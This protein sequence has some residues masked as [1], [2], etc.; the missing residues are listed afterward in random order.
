MRKA[1]D[2]YC[3]LKLVRNLEFLVCNAW[4]RNRS[5]PHSTTLRVATFG[6][7]RVSSPDL[8]YLGI[9]P[10][11]M[12]RHKRGQNKYYHTVPRTF[13][14]SSLHSTRRGK[15]G[16][17]GRQYKSESKEGVKEK[18]GGQDKAEEGMSMSPLPRTDALRGI[19][20]PRG[21][22]AH[23]RADTQQ[24]RDVR[25]LSGQDAPL[26]T[27]QRSRHHGTRRLRKKAR[28]EEE[29]EGRRQADSRGQWWPV[30]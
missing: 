5:Y 7:L 15:H 14:L 17:S 2:A 20:P 26:I 10:V 8:P 18:R 1:I 16:S 21:P 13:F 23:S 22:P 28:E 4:C 11:P 3:C 12:E 29:E 30:T 27:Q 25:G 9:S 19:H 24:R 6:C